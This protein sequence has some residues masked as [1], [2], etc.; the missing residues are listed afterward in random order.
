MTV[1]HVAEGKMSPYFTRRAE[2][3]SMVLLGEV[4]G[5]FRLPDA[6]PRRALFISAG[7][8][9]TPIWS[10]PRD[11]ERRDGLSD[12]FHLHSSRLA[13]EVPNRRPGDRQRRLARAQ[14]LVAQPPPWRPGG[15]ADPGPPTRR[16]GAG[17]R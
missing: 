10:M 14:A 7:S 4:E 15:N 1:K 12:V 2:P 16:P 11:L 13:E 17:P 9:I 5:E 3:G 6:L 8:G